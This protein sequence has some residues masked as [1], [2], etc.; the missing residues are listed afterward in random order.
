MGN[1]MKEQQAAFQQR[2]GEGVFFGVGTFGTA[3]DAQRGLGSCFRVQ[4]DGVSKDLLLQS[5]N[6]GSD[7]SGNQFDLQIGDGG[8]GA[9]KTCPSTQRS[10]PP[11][12]KQEMI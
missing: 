6:T 9:F 3:D 7:V 12:S 8:A 10:A 2:T 11:W 4:V 5:I 1:A